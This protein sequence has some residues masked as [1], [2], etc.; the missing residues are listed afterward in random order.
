MPTVPR[1]STLTLELVVRPATL[2]G[3]VP[4]VTDVTVDI[5]SPIA[6][7]LVTDA[8][9]PNRFG[10]SRPE[11]ETITAQDGADTAREEERERRDSPNR[12]YDR[13]QGNRR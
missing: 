7:Q 2:L 3:P 11:A 6:A 12:R 13:H 10:F 9:G 1:G 4:V 8:P 5:L